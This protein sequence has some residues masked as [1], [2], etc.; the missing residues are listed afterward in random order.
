MLRVLTDYDYALTTLDLYDHGTLAIDGTTGPASYSIT[1]EMGM[2]IV[3]SKKGEFD[4]LFGVEKDQGF[5]STLGTIYQTFGGEPV[6]EC[7]GEGCQS[8]V[9]RREEP[10]PQR[11]Q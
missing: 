11:W 1:Y 2:G 8:A 6:P 7:R 4:G 3:A 10:C 5:E 9:I